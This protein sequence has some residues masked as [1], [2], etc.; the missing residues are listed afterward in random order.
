M[1]S[2]NDLD[3]FLSGR[4]LLNKVGFRL[5]PGETVALVGANGSG[6][7]TLLKICAGVLASDGGTM[8]IPKDW[9]IGYLPQHAE[10][11]SDRPL[12]DELR[13]VFAEVLSHQD[14]LD[15]LA[16]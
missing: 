1:L 3:K 13:S 11:E 7:S 8:A 15:V 14:E 16:H 2:V 9:T 5:N 6:K 10:M 4:P 12:L